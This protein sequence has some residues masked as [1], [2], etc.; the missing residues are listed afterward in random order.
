MLGIAL[1]VLHILIYLIL[2]T[3]LQGGNYY[4]SQFA[5][6]DIEA[7]GGICLAQSHTGA[8]Q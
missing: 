8:K 7:Q 4:Y 5:E 6:D 2:K 1:S 3:A